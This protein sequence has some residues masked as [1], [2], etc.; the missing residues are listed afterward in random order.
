MKISF[1]EGPQGMNKESFIIFHL[2]LGTFCTL[3]FVLIIN[4]F[5]N[6]KLYESILFSIFTVVIMSTRSY[7][8]RFHSR[9]TTFPKIPYAQFIDTDNITNMLGRRVIYLDFNS[10]NDD[11]TFDLSVSYIKEF[12]DDNQVILLEEDYMQASALVI[13][14]RIYTKELYEYLIGLSFEEQ[15]KFFNVDESGFDLFEPEP[16]W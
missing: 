9:K 11:N 1:K 16:H 7:L 10:I 15:C 13:H 3:L 14:S 4:Y 2:I 8:H 6:D 5:T 12:V